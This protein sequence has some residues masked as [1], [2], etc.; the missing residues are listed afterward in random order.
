ML[1]IED[2]LRLILLI[3]IPKMHMMV[4]YLEV[5]FRI[6]VRLPQEEDDAAEGEEDSEVLVVLV[7]EAEAM[8]TQNHQ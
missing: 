4:G 6:G 1:N 2:L 3:L 5:V 7:L 8:Q